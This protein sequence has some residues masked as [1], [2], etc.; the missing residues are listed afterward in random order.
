MLTGGAGKDRYVLYSYDLA[1]KTVTDF[2]VGAT[3]DVI[4]VRLLLSDSAF[5]GYSSGNPLDPALGY[6]R[7]EQVGANTLVQWDQDGAAGSVEGWR[8]VLTLNSVTASNVTAENFAPIMA[9]DGSATGLTLTGTESTD[10]LG[11]G[12]GKDSISGLAGDDDLVG[13]ADDDTLVGGEGNDYLYGGTGNDLLFAGAQDNNA[14]T[15]GNYLFGVEGDDI[16]HGGEFGDVQFGGSG[17]DNLYG[18]GGD[19]TLDGGSGNNTL[20]G[21]A[22]DD[23]FKFNDYARTSSDGDLITGGIAK[24]ALFSL[25]AFCLA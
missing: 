4:D 25:A 23:W 17:N 5:F 9:P 1:T 24:T 21:G 10:W 14:D 2:A 11:G 18:E 8:T 6:M 3:G 15:D 12:L 13:D 22:G 20:L 19:D 16:L 7:L